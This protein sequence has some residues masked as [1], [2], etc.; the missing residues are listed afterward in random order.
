MYG[1]HGLSIIIFICFY[2]KI[3]Q[4]EIQLVLSGTAI[5]LLDPSKM[6]QTNG[7]D[8]EA[9]VEA[10]DDIFALDEEQLVKTA[11]AMPAEDKNTG[12]VSVLLEFTIEIE[13]FFV[14][15]YSD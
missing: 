4:D 6:E 8:K 11:P 15:H 14:R 2:G 1:R 9:G 12:P 7:V 5:P 3:F 10:D 13:I